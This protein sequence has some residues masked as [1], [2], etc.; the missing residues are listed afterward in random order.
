MEKGC[1]LTTGSRGGGTEEKGSRLA[2]LHCVH[3]LNIHKKKKKIYVLHSQCVYFLWMMNSVII[4][5]SERR[6]R[7]TILDNSIT[8]RSRESF[9]ISLYLR[10]FN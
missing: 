5:S 7:Y 10:I 4:V 8:P 6:H 3:A 2:E 9:P 1:K